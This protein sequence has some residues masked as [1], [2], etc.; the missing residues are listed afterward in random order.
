ME[1]QETDLV[2][3]NLKVRK[4]NYHSRI[5]YLTSEIFQFTS[6]FLECFLVVVVGRCYLYQAHLKP[7]QQKGDRRC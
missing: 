5:I 2:T 1:I 4:S 3:K 6:N 7:L